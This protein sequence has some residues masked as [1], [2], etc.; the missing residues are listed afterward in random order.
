MK[1]LRKVIGIACVACVLLVVIAFFA[2]QA[3]VGKVVANAIRTKGTERLGTPVTVQSV[4]FRLLG[5]SMRINQLAVANPDQTGGNLF[6][7]DNVLADVKFLPLLR[8]RVYIEELSTSNP[9]IE[10]KRDAQGRINLG[11]LKGAEKLPQPPKE[12][13]KK[14]GTKKGGNILDT[15]RSKVDGMDVIQAMEKWKDKLDKI[16]EMIFS[17]KGGKEAEKP[18]GGGGPSPGVTVDLVKLQHAVVHYKDEKEPNRKHL[19]LNGLKLT[20]DMSRSPNVEGGALVTNA[21]LQLGDEKQS[22]ETK[23]GLGDVLQA[24]VDHLKDVVVAK[25]KS[26]V[27]AEAVAKIDEA[28]KK[29]EQV[30]DKQLEKVKGIPVAEK[31]LKGIKG[32]KTTGEKGKLDNAA[33]KLKKKLDKL[34]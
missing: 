10:I 34:F 7:A 23:G 15:I 19:S 32:N 9:V 3:I 20:M 5:A 30:I 25:E 28:K 2:I 22:F 4:E 33:D 29:A 11:R 21:T 26:A 13:A 18:A 31:L 12:K 17:R 24:V 14:G 8:G 16:D 27:K 1:K 6:Q